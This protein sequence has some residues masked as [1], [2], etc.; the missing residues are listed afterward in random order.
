[1]SSPHPQTYKNSQSNQD[2]PRGQEGL[3]GRCVRRPITPGWSEYDSHCVSAPH[4]NLVPLIKI[5][6]CLGYIFA[7]HSGA[8]LYPQG[9]PQALKQKWLIKQGNIEYEGEG[10]ICF[11]VKMCFP[12]CQNKTEAPL[13][14]NMFIL[15]LL[16][17]ASNI[18]LLQKQMIRLRKL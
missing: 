18:V 1:M 5:V 13:I 6:S 15:W 17:P 14:R 10:S 12:R 16:L 4:C 2:L 7:D 3:R 11:N 9:I 8:F